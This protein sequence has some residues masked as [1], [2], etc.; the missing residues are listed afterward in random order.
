MKICLVPRLSG[1]GGMVSFQY[2]LA[3]GLQRRG[4][5]VSYSLDDETCDAVLVIGGTRQLPALWRARRRG[6][7]IV[8]RLNG[9][10]WLQRVHRPGHPGTGL[11]HFLRAEYSN[12]LL[13]T[14]RDRLTQAVIYQSEFARGWWERVYGRAPGPAHVVFNGVDLQRYSPEGEHHRPL[15]CWR[16]LLVEGSLMGG[17]EMGLEAAFNLARRLVERSSQPVELQIAGRVAPAVQAGWDERARGLGMANFHLSWAGLVPAVEI[18]QLDRSA[19]L[20][21]SAD[22]NAACPNSVIEALACGLP[23]LAFD[24]GAL[25]ELVWADAGRLAPYGGDPWRLDPPN[26]AGL[27]NGALEILGQQAHFR[28]AARQLAQEQF[29][30]ETMVDRYLRVLES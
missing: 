25:S 3:D 24:T 23:V 22:L 15:D 27:V 12:F 21:Y 4:V 8:Q 29:S 1:V 5:Q 16:L 13:R 17:Y 28:A 11:R 26:T 18:P 6:V 10:N 19:H 9:M 20:L 14:I 30:L 2:K 7:K